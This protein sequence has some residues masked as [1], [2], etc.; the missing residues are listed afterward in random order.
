MK[1]KIVE[2]GFVNEFLY[3]TIRYAGSFLKL[4]GERTLSYSN[5]LNPVWSFTTPNYIAI[6][7]AR[8]EH[9]ASFKLDLAKKSVLEVGAGIGSLTKFFEDLECP[10][11]STDSRPENI[12]E[13]AKRWPYRKLQVL[14]LNQTPDISFLGSFDVIFCY[15]TLYHLSRPEQALASL[16]SICREMILLETIVSPGNNMEINFVKES[17]SKTQA[18]SGTGS[19]PTRRWVMEMLRKYF[20]YSYITKTQPH[21]EDFDVCWC[22]PPYKKK[23]HRAVFLGSKA[24][25]KNPLLSEEIPDHQTWW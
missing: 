24:P 16:S 20:G 14:D 13:I 23:N 15:G 17:D 8:L 18:M 25:L 7:K 11:L 5:K 10:I 22:V 4:A 21:H 2:C 19:R 3:R 6:N 12:A 9:L 1:G